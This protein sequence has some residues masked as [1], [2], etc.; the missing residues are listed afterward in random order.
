MEVILATFFY[1]SNRILDHALIHIFVY[2]ICQQ[3]AGNVLRVG[4]TVTN[5]MRDGEGRHAGDPLFRWTSAGK[6]L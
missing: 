6:I 4:V 3:I 5:S 2:L 1:G